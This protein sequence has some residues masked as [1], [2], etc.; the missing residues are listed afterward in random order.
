MAL[1]ENAM[2]CQESNGFWGLLQTFIQSPMPITQKLLNWYDRFGRNLPWRNTQNPYH[3]LVSEIMLQQTQVDRVKLFYRPW[4]KKFPTWKHLA[5]ASTSE[6][7]S[8]WAG[9]GYN[10]RALVL[11][12]IAQHVIKFGVPN[13]EAAWKQLKG[14]G[15]YTS[16]AMAVFALN[17]RTLPIDTNI[18]RVLARVYLGIPFPQLA[19]D[20]R[21]VRHQ[22]KILPKKNRYAEIPQALFDLAT[23]VCKKKPNCSICPLKSD[24]KATKKFALGH[25]RI[26]KQMIKKSFE[27]RHKQKPFP[28]RIYRGRILTCIREH[29]SLEIEHL[30]SKIDP[31]FDPIHDSNWLNN[32]IERMAKDQLIRKINHTLFI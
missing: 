16:A 12:E 25:V 28:D 9:L 23:D 24:C 17:K 3:I 7:L 4:L 6:I 8:A 31:S 20:Q 1:N 10:R 14:I 22:N 18:R 13:T 11:R 15:S 19:D 26:P 32:M 21:I 2:G 30:G 29:G 5:D 27:S